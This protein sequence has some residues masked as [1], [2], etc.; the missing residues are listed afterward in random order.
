VSSI[1]AHLSEDPTVLMT[2]AR[3]WLLR[4]RRASWDSLSL[5]LRVFVL[6]RVLV[7]ASGALSLALGARHEGWEVFDPGGLSARLG[8][9]GN[10]LT[11]ASVRWDS[12]HYLSIAVHGYRSGAST[13]F[14]PLYPLLVHAGALLCGSPAAAGVTI[15]L[16]AFAVALVLL[17]RLTDLELGAGVAD[18]AVALLAFAPLGF[19]FSAV[20]TESL[21][22][23]VSIGCFYA[24]R[25]ERWGLAIALAALSSA[26]RVTGV[27]LVAPLLV[28]WWQAGRRP[29]WVGGAALGGGSGLLAFLAFCAASGYGL[30]APLQHQTGVVHEHAMAGPIIGMWLGLRAGASGAWQLVSGHAHV[31]APSVAGALTLPAENVLLLGVLALALATAAIVVRTLPGPYGVYVIGS[32]LVDLWA[33]VAQRPL[34]SLDRYCLTLFPLWIAAASR[35]SDHRARRRLLGCSAALLIFFAGQF[36]RWAFIA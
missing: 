18:G 4:Q 10:A 35:L 25:R 19:F 32:L 12:I 14:F 6:S 30:L 31:L 8:T 22:L 16:G 17:H 11:A 7:L 23:A 28:A 3:A 2:P 24:M 21:F 15:S 26:T 34:S 20:Y 29:R 27:L 5:A 13:V 36:A 33:P 9:V 1:D